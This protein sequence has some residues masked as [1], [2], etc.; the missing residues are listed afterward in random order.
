MSSRA[1]HL[2]IDARPRGPRGLLAAELV[3]G[4]SVLDHLLEVA[5]ELATPSEPVVVHARADDHH[6]LRE[7]VGEPHRGDLV[8]VSGPPRANTTVLRTDRF[9]DARRLRRGLRRGRSPESAVLWRLD[10]PEALQ[11][12]DEELRR[13][14]TYQPLGKYWAFPLARSLAQVLSP[15]WIRPNHLTLT[16]AALMLLAAGLIAVAPVGWPD[17]WITALALALALVLDTADGR[18]ARLQGTSSAFGRWLDQV[19][20]ELAD[21]AIHAAIAW[22]AF[23]Q[24]SQPIWLVL[25]IVYASGKYLFLVQ[26][27]LGDELEAR[28]SATASPTGATGLGN[29]SGA[30]RRVYAGLAGVL[31]L[32]GH[33][34]VRW[35]LWIALAMLGRLDVALAAYAI[36]FPARA[37]A[38]SVRKGV[39]Y[40]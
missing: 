20:D 11:N 19:L 31:R 15:T 5:V 22:A 4:R 21:L 16:A 40:A 3:L 34:D 26:S 7:L 30:G 38:G 14:L 2:V 28:S 23:C 8:F 35:H 27:I 36:Y 32:I 13:R 6:Q 12:A 1:V 17:R 39:R 37:V 29:P 10:R 33:A 24:A 9:Y 25:G 18:L